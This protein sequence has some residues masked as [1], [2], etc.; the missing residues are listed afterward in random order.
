MAVALAGQAAVV[1]TQQRLIQ[2]QKEL[3]DSFIRVLAKAIE[4]QSSSTRGHIERVTELTMKIARQLNRT[5]EGPFADRRLSDHELEELRI[6]AWLHDTGKITT[7]GHI[8]NKATKLEKIF[9]RMAIIEMRLLAEYLQ[10]CPDSE[11]R[12]QKSDT[13]KIRYREDVENELQFLE[14][15]NRGSEFLRDEDAMRVEPVSYTHLTL[16]TNREV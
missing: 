6:A 2:E 8:I 5:T 9:D 3:F 13:L 12:P 1:L 14:S 10:S 11:E 16:P 15:V 7:P 4:S